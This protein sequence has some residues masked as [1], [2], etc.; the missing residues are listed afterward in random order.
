MSKTVRA[1]TLG[2]YGGAMRKEGDVFDIT[3]TAKIGKWMEVISDNP[4]VEA[5]PPI[6]KELFQKK[7]KK[8]PGIKPYETPPEIKPVHQ[9][10]GVSIVDDGE[11]QPE[12]I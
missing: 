6:N 3:D 4:G 1:K 12:A 10:G 2:F 11:G 5:P 9:D 7:S 8:V